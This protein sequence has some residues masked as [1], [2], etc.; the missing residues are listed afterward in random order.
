MRSSVAYLG[1]VIAVAVCHALSTLLSLT[2]DAE[3][4]FRSGAAPH[5]EHRWHGG[6]FHNRF[7]TTCSAR[8]PLLLAC[9][10][11]GVI[12]IFSHVASKAWLWYIGDGTIVGLVIASI[13]ATIGTL[14]A[15]Y[16]S[17]QG[18]YLYVNARTLDTVDS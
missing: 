10:L 3:V 13:V 11:I 9:C 1:I 18:H 6:T 16:A 17:L 15:Q 12:Y 2:L 7:L 14:V 8:A 5:L 4:S